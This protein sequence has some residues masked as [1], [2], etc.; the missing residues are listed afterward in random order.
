MTSVYWQPIGGFRQGGYAVSMT[1][2]P[3]G[4]LLVLSTDSFFGQSP[5]TFAGAGFVFRGT[6]DGVGGYTWAQEAMIRPSIVASLDQC[7]A[8]CSIITGPAGE[9]VAALGT[10][11]DDHVGGD[12]GTAAVFSRGPG[13][14]WIEEGILIA[15][16]AGGGDRFGQSLALTPERIVVGSPQD[17]DVIGDSGSAYLF[18]RTPVGMAFQWVFEA[19]LTAPDPSGG[20]KFGSGLALLDDWAFAGAPFDDQQ[21]LSAGAVYAFRRTPDSMGGSTWNFHSKITAADAQPGDLFGTALAAD[22][23]RLLVGAIFGG[24]AEEG[25]GYVFRLEPGGGGGEQWTQEARLVTLPG[26]ATLN[27]QCGKAV[28]IRDGLALLGA[29]EDDD[30]A[31]NT[32]TAY[33][34]RL[35][36]PGGV[37][38]WTQSSKIRLPMP[39]ITDDF[40]FSVALARGWCAVGSPAHNQYGTDKGNTFVHAAPAPPV[41][42]DPP[43]DAAVEACGTLVLGAAASGRA[44]WSFQW[45]HEDAPLVDGGRVSGAHSPTLTIS[46]C[47]AGDAG[48]YTLEASNDCGVSEASCDVAV[49]PPCCPGDADRDGTVAFADVTSILSNFG[50]SYAPGVGPGDAD[51]DGAVN[52]AD[53]AAVLSNW[54]ALCP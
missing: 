21:G 29:H 12:A 1:A 49:T 50:A 24:P 7:G 16:D 11:L 13:P 37:P 3:S 22:S 28:A 45:K 52:F 4:Q 30:L 34:F 36:T 26:G 17:D 6:P 20:A 48:R 39:T 46:F 53:V 8:A 51:A 40:G 41:I 35:T 31:T 2:L 42:H 27:D 54:A 18:R 44:P 9:V 38:A 15:A 25:V 23:G 43:D 10:P 33:L 14:T 47:T 19:K 5:L 32:G